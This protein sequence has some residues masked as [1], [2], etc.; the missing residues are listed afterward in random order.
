MAVTEQQPHRFERGTDGP[1]VI[2]VGI[3]GSESSM[4][5]AAYAAGSPGARTPCSPSST[6]S[7]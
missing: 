2:V 6:C 1:K 7:R 5:A 3:D 4:R